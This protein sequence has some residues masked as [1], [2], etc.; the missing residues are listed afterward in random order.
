MVVENK[1]GSGA[2]IAAELAARAEPDGYTIMHGPD[3]VFIFNPHLYPKLTFDPLKDF[4]PITSLV[5]NQIMLAVHPSVPA[6]TLKE[7][8]ELNRTANPPRF[9]AS[10]GNGSPHHLAM[11]MLK[12]HT[13]MNMV[14]VPYRGGGPA[15]IGLLAGEIDAMFGGGSLVPTIQSGK[16]RGLATTA[17]KRSPNLPDL[18][19]ID[20]V[21]PGYELLIW[22][23]LFAPAGTPAPIVE[24]LRTEVIEVLKQP[25]MVQKLAAPPARASP[26]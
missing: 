2:N 20:E 12:Q 17:L 9:Y 14:H 19:T 16:V 22:H 25:E 11:E 10:I 4:V 15:A 5:A 23:G 8:V 7:F 3:N 18:P 26:I 24:R 21:F 13:G 6:R 1:P